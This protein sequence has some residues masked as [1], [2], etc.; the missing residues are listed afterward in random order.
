MKDDRR[1]YLSRVARVGF[2][3]EDNLSSKSEISYFKVWPKSENLPHYVPHNCQKATKSK[4]QNA[5]CMMMILNFV[6]DN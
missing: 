2:V 5:E 1:G 3:K 4:L 6:F